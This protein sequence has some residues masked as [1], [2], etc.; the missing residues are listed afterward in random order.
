MQFPSTRIMHNLNKTDWRENMMKANMGAYQE[1]TECPI[2]S[3]SR[4]PG[5]SSL[6]DR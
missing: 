6:P 1:I 5:S 4:C 2:L 3:A